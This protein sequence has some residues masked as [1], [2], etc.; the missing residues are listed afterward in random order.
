LTRNSATLDVMASS[1]PVDPAL[2][3][4]ESPVQPTGLVNQRG[5]RDCSWGRILIAQQRGHITTEESGLDDVEMK[6]VF[7]GGRERLNVSMPEA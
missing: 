4:L 3:L 5:I 2:D 1:A 6:N 7:D